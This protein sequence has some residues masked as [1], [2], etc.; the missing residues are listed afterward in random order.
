MLTIFLFIN[1]QIILIIF[2]FFLE[3][4]FFFKIF[5]IFLPILII[6]QIFLF[7]S[8]NFFFRILLILFLHQFNN[9]QT[10]I[11]RITLTAVQSAELLFYEVYLFH[12][13]SGQIVYLAFQIT[14]IHSGLALGIIHFYNSECYKKYLSVII[15]VI[16]DGYIEEI[17]R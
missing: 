6:F 10:F 2:I 8:D 16:K 1:I 11:I 14:E 17:W 4:P 15:I 12:D 7:L 13:F 9:S 5:Q 3:F